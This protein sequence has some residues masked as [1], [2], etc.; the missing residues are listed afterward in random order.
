MR[1]Q[2]TILTSLLRRKLNPEDEEWEEEGRRIAEGLE[3]DIEREDEFI[4]WCQNRFLNIV[5]EREY[6]KGIK[7]KEEKERDGDEE[8]ERS[9]DMDEDE[10]VGETENMQGIGLGAA[11]KYL[12]QGLEPTKPPQYSTPGHRM[13]SG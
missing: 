4:E 8:D 1:S 6:V 7:T 2:E 9:E 11:L 5:E 3:V 13:N 12:A 10:G